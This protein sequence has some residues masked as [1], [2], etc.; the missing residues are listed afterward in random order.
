MFF[1]YPVAKS[2]KLY[3]FPEGTC[4]STSHSRALMRCEFFTI[5][6]TSSNMLSKLSPEVFNLRV[7]NNRQYVTTGVYTKCIFRNFSSQWFWQNRKVVCVTT[8]MYI[9]G[10]NIWSQYA[11][12]ILSPETPPITLVT[13][14]LY[15]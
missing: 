3:L 4:S 2:R 1:P 12:K 7:K 11:Q 8:Y 13:S 15:D 6:G 9:V 10:N 5:T 14:L